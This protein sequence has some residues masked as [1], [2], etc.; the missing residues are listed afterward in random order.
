MCFLFRNSN[1]DL[2]SKG[3]ICVSSDLI[4]ILVRSV[5]LYDGLF[6]D[7]E[8]MQKCLQFFGN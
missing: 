6:H 7:D 5:H 1:M 8:Q 4:N 3:D 2:H